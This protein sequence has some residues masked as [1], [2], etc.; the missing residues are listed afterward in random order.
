LLISIKPLAAW[1]GH[2][3]CKLRWQNG[4]LD[5]TTANDS[6]SALRAK[7]DFLSRPE[8]IPRPQAVIA[9]ET[10]MSWV[11]MAGERVY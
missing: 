11:F 7:V 3:P 4:A 6:A 2:R 10:H 1:V 5:Q 8:S 9:R